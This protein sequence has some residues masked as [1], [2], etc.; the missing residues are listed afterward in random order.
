MPDSYKYV[1]DLETELANHRRLYWVKIGFRSYQWWLLSALTILAIIVWLILVDRT[2]LIELSFFGAVIAILST[3]MDE[4]GYEYRLWSYNFH[5]LP[6]LP[7][8]SWVYYF[9]MPII[10]MLVYQY[11]NDWRSYSV[12]MVV[13]AAI[14]AFVFEPLLIRMHIYV[15]LKWRHI[16][17]FPIYFAIGVATKALV[18]KLQ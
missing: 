8:I 3:T 16:Y 5:L 1:R 10:Y 17:S 2:R 6:Q 11:F 4:Y 14:L 12:A 18:I 15:P 9:M 13:V 7:H